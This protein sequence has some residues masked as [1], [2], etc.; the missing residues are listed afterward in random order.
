MRLL[1]WMDGNCKEKSTT[2][3]VDSKRKTFGREK[4]V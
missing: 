2:G 3:H 4:D 1:E